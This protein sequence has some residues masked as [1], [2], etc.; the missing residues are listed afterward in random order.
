MKPA[1]MLARSS[2]DR[3]YRSLFDINSATYAPDVNI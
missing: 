3:N 1:E 2:Y